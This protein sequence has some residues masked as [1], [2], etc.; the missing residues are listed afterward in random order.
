[1]LDHW[2]DLTAAGLVLLATA[3]V[4][5]R[6]WRIISNKTGGCGSCSSCPTADDQK[7]PIVTIDKLTKPTHK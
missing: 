5:Q 2:Q 7:K 3:Y 4:A 1:M 6:A